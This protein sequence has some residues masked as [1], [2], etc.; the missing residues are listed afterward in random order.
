MNRCI[1]LIFKLS[2]LSFYIKL[3]I[4]IKIVLRDK[5]LIG[6]S[7][8]KKNTLLTKYIQIIYKIHTKGILYTICMKIV[9]KL[10]DIV[11]VFNWVRMM[12]ENYR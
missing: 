2:I 8:R 3:L 4:C 1:K 12:Y 11:V 10:Y 6:I 7:A 9:F 5:V